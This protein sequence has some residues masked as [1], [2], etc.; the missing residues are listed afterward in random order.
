MD[1]DLQLLPHTSVKFSL[2]E[3]ISLCFYIEQLKFLRNIW[4]TSH[5]S[6]AVK[7]KKKEKWAED[8]RIQLHNSHEK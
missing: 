3:N 6:K 4:G 2:D 8:T 1:G 5:A 7:K